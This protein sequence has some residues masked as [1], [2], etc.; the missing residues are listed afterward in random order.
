[1]GFLKILREH[2]PTL[3]GAQSSHSRPSPVRDLRPD[4]VHDAQP[5]VLHEQ[6]FTQNV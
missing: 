2:V 1:M 4:L 3:F 5:G 6:D